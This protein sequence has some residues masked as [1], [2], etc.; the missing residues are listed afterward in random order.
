MG[1]HLGRAANGALSERIIEV[2]TWDAYSAAWG[3]A[4]TQRTARA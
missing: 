2:G 4:E 3:D 1:G